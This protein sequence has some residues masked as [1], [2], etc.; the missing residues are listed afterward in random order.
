MP[1][2]CQISVR[3]QFL[4]VLSIF[5]LS[6]IDE[7]AGGWA[8]ATAPW[9]KKSQTRATS[10]TR[11]P[12]FNQSDGRVSLA[13]STFN[14]IWVLNRPAIYESVSDLSCEISAFHVKF[15]KLQRSPEPFFCF[16]L[17]RCQCTEP[18][19]VQEF[20]HRLEVRVQGMSGDMHGL[21]LPETQGEAAKPSILGISWNSARSQK[22][23]P[24]LR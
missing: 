21:G 19:E 16:M 23:S 18:I 11:N 7:H 2:L 3:S 24:I 22:A 5:R 10:K 13:K 1:G 14:W 20:I 15:C 6:L 8:Q 9:S 17:S 4:G 12:P